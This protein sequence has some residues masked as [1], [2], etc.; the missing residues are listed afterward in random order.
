MTNDITD[1]DARSALTNIETRRRQI[2][3]EIDI[4]RWYWWG[5][6]LGWVALGV[7]TDFGIGWLTLAATFTFGA[8]HSAVAQHVLSGRHGSRQLSVRARRRRP[9]SP[10]VRVQRPDRAG[11]GHDRGRGAGPCRRRRT[12]RSRSRASSSRSRCCSVGPGWSPQHAGARNGPSTRDRDRRSSTSSSTR[13]H[14]CRSSR[15]WPRR[16]GSTSRSCAIASASPTPRC[17][18]SSRRWRTPATSPSIAR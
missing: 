14:A 17:R 16:T 11:R 8:V 15:C 12:T 5:V 4:P 10:A 18:S 3:A 1:A 7:I 13:A 9:A 2:I 6:A